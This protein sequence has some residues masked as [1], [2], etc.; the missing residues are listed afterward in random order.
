MTF[1]ADTKYFEVY[2]FMTNLPGTVYHTLRMHAFKNMHGFPPENSNY[3]TFIVLIPA[4]FDRCT[5]HSVLHSN[6]IATL[7]ISVG[8]SC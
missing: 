6:N 1:V 5:S 4:A 3:P 8:L 2:V 7:S